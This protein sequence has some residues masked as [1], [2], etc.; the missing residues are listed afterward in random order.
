LRVTLASIAGILFVLPLDLA[1][2]NLLSL[3]SPTRIEAGVF[4]R[5]RASLTTVL[6]SFAVRGLLFGAG[7]TLLVWSRQQKNPGA[8]ILIFLLQA[9]FAFAIYAWALTRVDAVALEHREGLISA[10]SLQ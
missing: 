2:G 9:A 7:A 3:Y 4:G 1:A 8:A 10:L 5:Q 6:A